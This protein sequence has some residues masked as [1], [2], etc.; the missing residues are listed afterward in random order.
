MV[1]SNGTQIQRYKETVLYTVCM[2]LEIIIPHV[3]QEGQDD[4]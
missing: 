2:K 4:P 3:K 1:C